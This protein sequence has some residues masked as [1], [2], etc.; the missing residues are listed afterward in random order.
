MKTVVQ[1][2]VLSKLDYANATITGTS[3][4]LLAP[5]RTTF[6][7]VARLITGAHYH[8][9]P[10]LK[11]LNWL[12]LADRSAFKVAYMKHKA[13]NTSNL[14]YLASMLTKAG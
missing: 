2:L 10:T 14:E 4:C 7:A 13:L 6:Q 12:P 9:T 5:M 11:A 3:K 1:S 8:I